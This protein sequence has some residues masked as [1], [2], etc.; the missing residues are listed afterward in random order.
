[1]LMRMHVRPWSPSGTASLLAHRGISA[2]AVHLDHRVRLQN[3]YIP[4]GAVT[5]KN[6]KAD[7][8]GHQK[9]IRAGFLRQAH[10]GIF[11]LLPMGFRVQEKIKRLIDKHMQNIGASRVSLSSFSSPSLWR[12]SGRYSKIG[13]ELFQLTDRKDARYLLSPTHEEEITSLVKQTVVSYKNLPLRLYQITRKYRDEFRPRKGLLR[14]REFMM[15][16]LYTFDVSVKSALATYDE[17]RATYDRLFSE[18]RLPMLVAEASSGDI[19]GNLSHEYHLATSQGEDDVINCST[20]GYTANSEIA[21]SSMPIRQGHPTAK[22]TSED[23]KVW[24]GISNDARTLVN[25][26]YSGPAHEAA[27]VNMH[28]VKRLV[29]NIDTGIEDATPNW[30]TALT[31]GTPFDDGE[32]LDEYMCSRPSLRF[33][34]LIDGSVAHLNIRS[35]AKKELAPVATPYSVAGA[36]VLGMPLPEY[37]SRDN[38]DEPLRLLAIQDG[39][40]C[41]K[42]GSGVLRVEK[43]IEL[44]HTFHL[45]DRYSKPMGVSINIPPSKI[46]QDEQ[47]ATPGSATDSTAEGS[48]EQDVK[49]HM[50]MGCHGIGV[51][52]IMGAVADH[53]A[54]D[55]GLNWPRAIAPYEVAILAHKDLE[56]EAVQVYDV[57]DR[58]GGGRDPALPPMAPLDLLLDDRDRSLPWKLKDADLM[59]YPV[60]VVLGKEW[61]ETR[62]CEVQCR[63]LGVVELLPVDDLYSR[64]NQLLEKL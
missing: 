23:V 46:D 60:L 32:A 41:P 38:N 15:K 14:S 27:S 31:G 29:P 37:I 35:L 33:V 18:M 59:G 19:G 57:L 21:S 54:D 20:C 4:L 28:A 11:H 25:V 58:A 8:D 40:A 24:H 50:Q 56:E 53:L 13:S 52:R 34:N 61:R 5:D 22:P 49:V 10:A 36:Q 47:A 16:D 3:S 1:M 12:R 62:R 63:Q 30:W 26:W 48:E 6:R 44:G 9:L 17:V 64:V 43:A 2:R 42:C 51:S 7:E 55:R 45:G 39:D